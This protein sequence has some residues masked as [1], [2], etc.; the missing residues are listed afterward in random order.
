MLLSHPF[1]FAL[2]NNTGK[3]MLCPVIHLTTRTT[4]KTTIEITIYVTLCYVML[5]FIVTLYCCVV[6]CCV[7]LCCVVLCYDM[8]YVMICYV[9]LC[10]VMLCYVMWV[11]WE[12]I[13]MQNSYIQTRTE[14]VSMSY[15][16]KQQICCTSVGMQP[17]WRTEQ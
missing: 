1:C 5:H 8:M 13:A 9:M 7:V 14:G 16:M 2:Q 10:Y 12:V 3:S 17:I 15:S 11:L 6:L 4:V